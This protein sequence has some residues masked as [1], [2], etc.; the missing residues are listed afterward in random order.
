MPLSEFFELRDGCS[1][2][3]H[4]LTIYKPCYN[5]NLEKFFFKNRVVNA[6]NKLPQHVVN[7]SNVVSFKRYVN[8]LPSNF[9]APY[10]FIK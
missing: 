2:R 3:G 8:N 4:S 1:T 7:A 6:W 10:L 9:Y 5:T